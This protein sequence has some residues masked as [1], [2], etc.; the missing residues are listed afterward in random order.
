[1]NVRCYVK[2]FPVILFPFPSNALSPSFRKTVLSL[3]HKMGLKGDDTKLT[4]EL[5]SWQKT[6]LGQS[7]IWQGLRKMAADWLDHWTAKYKV[8]QR[9]YT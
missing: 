2:N 5:N 3:L 9:N 6:I 7:D 1:M 4:G 8:G